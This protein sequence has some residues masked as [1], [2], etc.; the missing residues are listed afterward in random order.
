[1]KKIILLFTAICLVVN[2]YAA[3]TLVAPPLNAG[4]VYITVG[5]NGEKISLLDLSRMKVKNLQE[6]TG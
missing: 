4:K 5:K 6:L 1:M 2:S 3:F